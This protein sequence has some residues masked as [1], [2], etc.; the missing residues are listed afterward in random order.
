MESSICTVV[1]LPLVPVTASHG[2]GAPSGPAPRSRQASSTSP[3]TGTP[4][5][6]AWAM[7]GADGFHPGET[8]SRSVSA[9]RVVVVP[10]PRRTSAPSTPR[11]SAFSCRS[12]PPT[13]S[14]TAITEAPRWVRLSATANPLTPKPATVARTSDQSSWRRRALTSRVMASCDGDPAGV[15]DA[16]TGGDAEAGDD[17]EPDDDRD[18]LPAEQLEVVLERCHPEHPVAGSDPED[19]AHQRGSSRQLEEADLQHHRQRDH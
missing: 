10:G 15:E 9:G 19:L 12:C 13:D 2:A 16:Q 18:L 7:R 6:R 4:S 8:T 14:S 3:H 17:P 11:S 5:A 1:V